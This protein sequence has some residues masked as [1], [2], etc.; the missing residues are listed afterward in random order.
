[1]VH[2]QHYLSRTPIFNIIIYPNR[3]KAPYASSIIPMIAQPI[4]TT[5]IPPK[6][7]AV[8]LILWDWKKNLKVLSNPIMKKM[9][10]TK[11][12]W[13]DGGREERET[14]REREREGEGGEGGREGERE[15]GG[16][17]ERELVH[18]HIS[19]NHMSIGMNPW[20]RFLHFPLLIVLCR[21]SESL[22][23]WERRVQR[24]PDPARSLKLGTNFF[25]LWN[26]IAL[27]CIYCLL[28]ISVKLTDNILNACPCTESYNRW[29]VFFNVLH[30]VCH[31]GGVE[32]VT[33]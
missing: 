25:L 33:F 21:I 23:V 28:C 13:R 1:M 19:T 26:S 30:L 15:G 18:V 24:S 10:A 22:L 7:Q 32:R 8:P 4:N 29:E 2:T 27:Q 9:P 5:S 17:R 20:Y 3:Q 6:K 11:R 12:I 16:G 31:V 14:Q